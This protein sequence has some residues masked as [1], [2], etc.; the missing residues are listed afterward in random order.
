[1]DHRNAWLVVVK[2]M[3]KMHPDKAFLS[4]IVAFDYL[5]PQSLIVLSLGDI[6]NSILFMHPDITLFVKIVFSYPTPL[7]CTSLSADVAVKPAPFFTHTWVATAYYFL[8]SLLPH[9][10]SFNVSTT[11]LSFWWSRCMFDDI[12][13]LPRIL[14]W[15][16]ITDSQ[17]GLP[18]TVST[19][20]S[21][22][23]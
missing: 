9:S 14:H 3:K 16:P 5:A 22:T 21:L 12:N 7:Q 17:T 15:L 13:L 18:L 6:S 4:F 11:L 23:V 19:T 20:V 2:L 1:M 10:T 8:A